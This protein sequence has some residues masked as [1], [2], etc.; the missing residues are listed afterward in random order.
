MKHAKTVLG[1]GIALSAAVMNVNTAAAATYISNDPGTTWTANGIDEHT[2]GNEMKGMLVTALFT[3]GSSQT[4]AWKAG[5]PL[6]GHASGSKWSLSEWGDTFSYLFVDGIW[7]LENK[8]GKN[9]RSLTL[10]GA[11]G[12]TVFDRT[13]PSI[14]TPG[15]SLGKDFHAISS[16][17]GVNLNVTYRDAVALVGESP[18][19]DLYRVLDIEFSGSS[20]LRS[21]KCFSFYAD[22]DNA[23]G[24]TPAIPLPAAA[25]TGLSM[26]GGLGI[27]GRVRK[28]LRGE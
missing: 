10:D 19:G 16:P 6:A 11:P 4:A 21:G 27:L 12:N 8:S 7:N 13:H 9:I 26:L 2:M 17:S 18:V 25:W 20:G 14:G 28:T 15:S 24:L 22:T 3:D 5:L 1:M 23:C